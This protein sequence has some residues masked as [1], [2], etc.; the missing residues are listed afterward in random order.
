MAV[1]HIWELGAASF[2]YFYLTENCSYRMLGILEVASPRLSLISKLGWPVLPIDT[3]QA[4]AQ[5]PGLVRSITYRPSTRVQFR[6]RLAELDGV[7]SEL[8]F[9]LGRDPDAPLPETVSLERRMAILD[10]ALDLADFSYSKEL[11]EPSSGA[12]RH[13]QR[14]LQRRAE[15]A[16]PS[17]PL[18]IPR[19][20]SENPLLG[21]KRGRLDLGE[22]YS[23][24]DG[25]YQAL[26]LRLALHDWSD[27]S[28][29][30]PETLSI[31][32]L[33]LRLRHYIERQRFELE[34][35][36]LISITS[37]VPIDAFDQSISWHARLGAGRMRDSGCDGCFA[38]VAEAGGG[39]AAG[40]GS[41]LL[42]F[43]NLNTAL[44]GLAPI[45]GGLAELPLRLGFGPKFGLRFRPIHDLVAALRGD[46]LYL[47]AQTP[48]F[49][50]SGSVSVRW[51][52]SRDFAV[53]L[54]AQLHPSGE[55]AHA[56]SSLYF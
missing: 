35:L 17:P 23:T 5:N 13:K 26:D 41:Q 16:I 38:G 47:P 21:H 54:E 1:A 31:N 9:E 44:L 45:D 37:L 14:L 53:S 25:F 30:Y 2:R 48:S 6:H 56:A 55:Y 43:V 50:W 7:E 36:S 39:A 10:A 4:V 19:P 15:L 27:P 29:G 52:Y 24:A 42:A 40:L 8:V 51:M 49:T 28:A 20:E 18:L 46:L 12:S 32:F 11:L 3:L 33:P 22:G 34:E